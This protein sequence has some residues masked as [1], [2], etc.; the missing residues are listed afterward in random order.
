MTRL[1]ISKV[2]FPASY[3]TA[4]AIL[5]AS[6]F[7]VTPAAQA[8]N[9]QLEELDQSGGPRPRHERPQATRFEEFNRG[10]PSAF[11]KLRARLSPDKDYITWIISEPS[12]VMDLRT[13]ENFRLSFVA[14]TANEDSSISHM[15]IAWS[16]HDRDGRPLTGGAAQTGEDS[17]QTEKMILDGWGMTP[18]Y[19]VFTDGTLDTPEGIGGMLYGTSK[20]HIKVAHV[21]FEVP[22]EGCQ[23][24]L[25]FFKAYLEHPRKPYKRFGLNL[26]PVRFEGG[27]CGSFASS[28]LAKA[29]VLAGIHPLLWRELRSTQSLM[30]VGLGEPPKN[31]EI[32]LPREYSGQFRY[33]WPGDLQL[34][35]WTANDG[36]PLRLIDPELG[37][38]A[39]RQVGLLFVKQEKI[40][41]RHLEKTGFALRV[42][43]GHTAG[44]IDENFD[45]QAAFVVNSVRKDLGIFMRS[46]MKATPVNLGEHWGLLVAH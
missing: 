10:W 17:N 34:H 22:R 39:L 25:S 5:L 24:M 18:F 8:R 6:A 9:P 38:L 21:T 35:S 46:G 45:E 40:S 19:S 15:M 36:P 44:P 11:S 31:V 16:C 1:R 37:M 32:V 7:F 14:N 3:L 33:V 13:A 20:H 41:R 42:I 2:K 27:G 43:K 26:D 23:R 29:G 4:T 12:A 28:M 30:G